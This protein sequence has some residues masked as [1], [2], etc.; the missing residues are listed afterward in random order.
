VTSRLIEQLTLLPI[1]P[2]QVPN[3]SLYAMPKG[4]VK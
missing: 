1:H 2:F 4:R 3:S